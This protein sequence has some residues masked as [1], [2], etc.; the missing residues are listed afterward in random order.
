[1]GSWLQG[2]AVVLRCTSP[3]QWWEKQSGCSVQPGYESQDWLVRS[4]WDQ[5][6]RDTELLD[7]SSFRN[8]F[9]GN[10]D[11]VIQWW[12]YCINSFVSGRMGWTSSD[13]DRVI[14]GRCFFS[15]KLVFPRGSQVQPVTPR[16]ECPTIHMFRSKLRVSSAW[17]YA[18]CSVKRV[19]ASERNDWT[20]NRH[21]T[22]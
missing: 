6:L 10:G 1:M 16:N 14:C 3:R 17:L 13:Y 15:E 22:Y 8:M 20:K 7:C 5:K 19:H 21:T 12:S 11:P 9:Q 4:C 18:R 2:D